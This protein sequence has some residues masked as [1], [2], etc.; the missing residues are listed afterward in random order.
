MVENISRIL[1]YHFSSLK[2]LVLPN[3]KKTQFI[4]EPYK[5]FKVPK[6]VHKKAPKKGL[7]NR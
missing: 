7:L 2:K 5:S 3:F 1:L 6:K 4:R